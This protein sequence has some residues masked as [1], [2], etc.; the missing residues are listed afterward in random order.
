M[1]GSRACVGLHARAAL[2]RVALPQAGLHGHVVLTREAV[3]AHSPS[4]CGLALT[5]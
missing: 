2:M 5:L 3:R 4:K 1:R